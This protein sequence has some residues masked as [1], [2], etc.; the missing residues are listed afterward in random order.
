MITRK[1]GQ[2][3]GDQLD[4]AEALYFGDSKF[5][6]LSRYYHALERVF[7][8]EWFTC[9]LRFRPEEQIYIDSAIN[10]GCA[11]WK[12]DEFDARISKAVALSP[13]GK[14]N[15]AYDQ[16]YDK[17]LSLRQKRNMAEVV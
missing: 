11:F 4:Y 2:S 15:R 6:V 10:T 9:K 17:A 13:N 5:A 8:L 1:L 16:L 14:G 12:E 7:Q 3:A